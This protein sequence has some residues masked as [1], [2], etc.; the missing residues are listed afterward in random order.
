M[1][2]RQ[3]YRL[4]EMIPG[5]LVW[6][7]FALAI[8]LSLTKPLWAIS[9]VIVYDLYWLFRVSYFVFYLIHAWR[10]YRR[11]IKR[12]WTQELQERFPAVKEYFHVIFL[13]TYKEPFSVVEGTIERLTKVSYD[14]KKFIIVLAGESRDEAN[15]LR[16]ASD[17]ITR[18]GDSFKKI[19]VTV[20]PSDLPDEVPGKGSNLHWAGQK[21]KEYIDEVGI[22]YDRLIV[23]AFDIDT[24]V[25]P[26]YFSCLSYTYL[27]Y[28]DPQHASFQPAVLYNNNLWESPALVRI[29]ALG[30]TFWLMTELAR[31]ERLFTFSS[32]SMSWQALVDVGFWDKRIVTEDSRIF[33]QCF[34]RYEGNYT[35]VPI[36]VP[37]SMDMVSAGS[38]SASLLELYRQQR[39]WA[40]GVEHLP[41]MLWNF[42]KHPQIPWRKKLHYLW[43]LGEGMY[44]WATAPILITA[45]G[46]LP[47][48]LSRGVVNETVFAQNAPAVLALLMQLAMVGIF[49]SGILGMFLLPPPPSDAKVHHYILMLLQWALLPF[50]LVLFGSIPAVDAQTRLMIGRPLGFNV[51]KKVRSS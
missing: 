24:I 45:L 32:H 43:N 39:R 18:Y 8:I 19:I 31:P 13:P 50:T 28:P 29:A 3:Q 35:V 38:Y 34:L 48:F 47:L 17:V 1:T 23:S 40:W 30:T 44:T 41:F 33:L 22:A 14:P 46:Q 11:E 25:H 37:V 27:S 21:T 12:D 6:L 36:Y 16:Y 15:F 4:L 26:Q 10:R 49:V 9:L 2:N 51:T 20:H 7:T 42:R 5:T